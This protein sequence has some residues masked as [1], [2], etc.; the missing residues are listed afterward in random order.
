M[1]KR[2][3]AG[4]KVAF[5]ERGREMRRFVTVFVTLAFAATFICSDGSGLEAID[6]KEKTPG[7]PSSGVILAEG[8]ASL[9]G[10]TVVGTGTFV[11]AFYGFWVSVADRSSEPWD[12]VGAYLAGL[13]AGYGLGFP[14]GA[15]AG[16]TTVGG[17]TNQR[18]SFGWSWAG[19]ELGAIS[20]IGLAYMLNNTSLGPLAGPVLVAGPA[21]GAV[22]GYN[23]SRPKGT[24]A[25]NASFDKLSDP[26]GP[27]L[28]VL[29]PEVE[30]RQHRTSDGIREPVKGSPTLTYRL[31]VARLTF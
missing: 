28:S 26:D 5:D 29:L 7:E 1:D 21:A 27:Q 11:L 15:A 16:V 13:A 4:I 18:G 22:M 30:L 17:L 8:L 31:T 6:Q 23:L 14:L 24:Q 2:A 19:A 3:V 12:L 25:T 20:A 9:A 10:G